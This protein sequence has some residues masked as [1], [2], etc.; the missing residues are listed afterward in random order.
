MNI[1]I[2]HHTTTAAARA[3]VDEFLVDAK[4]K[5]GHMIKD[6]EQHWE[7]DVLH[8]A[9]KAQGMHVKGTVEVTQEDIV[10]D[11]SLP[12]FAKPFEGRIKESIAKQGTELFP[13]A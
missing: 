8:F 1:S 11:A 2:P 3:R 5:H 9:F 13:R 12:I 7:G 4:A 10:M 6:L